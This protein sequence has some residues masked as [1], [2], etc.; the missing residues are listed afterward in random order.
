M[1]KIQKAKVKVAT[2][3]NPMCCL[4]VLHN[5]QRQLEGSHA[6]TR[7]LDIIRGGVS[8]DFRHSSIQLGL[9]ALAFIIHNLSI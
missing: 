2:L 7:A 5:L 4:Y 1:I 3:T 8:N 9:N 6:L